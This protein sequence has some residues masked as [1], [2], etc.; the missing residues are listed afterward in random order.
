MQQRK[1][2]VL[3][4]APYSTLKQVMLQASKAFPQMELTVAIGAIT[5]GVKIL[6]QYPEDAFDCI[7]SRGGTKMEV[8]KYAKVPV[9]EI[10]I[11]YFDLLNI[12][13][14]VE[15]YHGKLAILAYENIAH[16][17]KILCDILQLPYS[18]FTIDKWHNAPEKVN[19]LRSM[20]YTL[21]IG[22]AVSVEYAEKVGMQ[23]IL[24]TSTIDSVTEAFSQGLH[25]TSYINDMADKNSLLSTC[26]EMDDSLI[27]AFDA[28]EQVVYQSIKP[29]RKNLPMICRHLIHSLT[30]TEKRS[31]SRHVDN[32][33]YNIEGSIMKIRD[34]R[35][36][37]FKVK[38]QKFLSTPESMPWLT[39]YRHKESSFDVPNLLQLTNP[40]IWQQA[41]HSSK[42]K[43][44]LCTLGDSGTDGVALYK[45]LFN[46]NSQ[47]Y[48]FLFIVDI[49]LFTLNTLHRF[50]EDSH[51]PLYLEK[52]IFLF[53][54]LADASSMIFDAWKN[55]LAAIKF[56][57]SSYFSFLLEGARSEELL[58]RQ[59]KILEDFN[60]LPL[61]LPPLKQ[62]KDIILNYALLLIQHD[63]HLHDHHIVG[64]EPEAISL[65]CQYDWPWNLT[66]LKR[67]ITE[68]IRATTTPWIS[69]H[70]IRT[71]L[72]NEAEAYAP[73][74]QDPLDLQK[75]LDGII[76]DIAQKVL[77]EE[78]YNQTRAAKRLHISRTTLWRILKKKSFASV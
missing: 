21:I 51:S 17:A 4:I 65:L 16:S 62:N 1:I 29:S 59:H 12:F 37:I 34:Q 45:Q 52:S 75:P 18:I 11:S 2:R 60:A 53:K 55:E 47:P 8:E 71:L 25:I 31:F 78:N 3:G 36:S 70:T 73:S 27:L 77:Q 39:M 46:K 40:A 15:N 32:V 61:I 66:Q 54:G 49:S 6:K 50:I 56:S 69:V 72:K 14:L 74:S 43:Q 57:T 9:I 63:N 5:E 48:E 10:P 42:E 13:K 28:A 33:F 67:V 41:I 23:S 64:L 30:Q 68:A 35:Y 26:L 58:Q 24:L 22:D 19:Q 44:A 76:Y 38:P 7:I 20:G